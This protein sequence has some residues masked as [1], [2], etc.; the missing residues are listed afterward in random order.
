MTVCKQMIIKKMQ[1]NI[2]NAVMITIKHLQMKHIKCMTEIN[3]TYTGPK[4]RP[5]YSHA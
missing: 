5:R 2:E 3:V 4:I 1:I